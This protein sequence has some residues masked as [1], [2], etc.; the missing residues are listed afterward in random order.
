MGKHIWKSETNFTFLYFLGN[1]K[2][3]TEHAKF[4]NANWKTNMETLRSDS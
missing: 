2:W 1:Q 3:E 4:A